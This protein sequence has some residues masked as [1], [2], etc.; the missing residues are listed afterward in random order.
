MTTKWLQG[1]RASSIDLGQQFGQE[2]AATASAPENCVPGYFPMQTITQHG[3]SCSRQPVLGPVQSSCPAAPVP[4]TKHGIKKCCAELEAPQEGVAAVPVLVPG[5]DDIY[6][7]NHLHS[8]L[9][10]KGYFPGDEEMESWLFGDQTQSALL[11]FQV[12]LSYSICCCPAHSPPCVK[13]FRT[14][15]LHS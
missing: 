1:L 5:C 7:V 14:Q 12:S 3:G 11:T 8:A 15:S 9:S 2:P 6:W 10:S 13:G 4:H